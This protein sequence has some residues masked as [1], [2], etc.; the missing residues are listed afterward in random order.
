MFFYLQN[1]S[2]DVKLSNLLCILKAITDI[3]S[4]Y[5]RN[6]NANGCRDCFQRRFKLEVK[7]MLT[8]SHP[9]KANS[10]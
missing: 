10:R 8:S 2:I 3:L 5:F 4:D 1:P 7:D 6:Y 9:K